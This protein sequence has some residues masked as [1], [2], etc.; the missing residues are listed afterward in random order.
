MLGASAVAVAAA[1]RIGVA[2]PELRALALRNLRRRPGRAFLVAT[3]VLLATASLASAAILGDSLRASIR[4]SAGTQLGPVREE[5]I[6]SGTETARSIAS[7][8]ERAH[9]AGADGV[10]PLLS[11]TTTV[12]G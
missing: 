11:L 8:I 6:G 1:V 7:A 12:R 10:L 5:V 9:L 3:G 2:R 4:R